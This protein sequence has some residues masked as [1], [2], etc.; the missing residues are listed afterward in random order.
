M[1]STPSAMVE[2]TYIWG[3]LAMFGVHKGFELEI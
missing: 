2:Q 1:F 3:T